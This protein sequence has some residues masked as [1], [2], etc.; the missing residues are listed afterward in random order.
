MG[1]FF[2]D[3]RFRSFV[4]YTENVSISSINNCID[5][6]VGPTFLLKFNYNCRIVHNER[7]HLKY[8]NLSS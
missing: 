6:Q 7:D 3:W 8:T 1:F 2:I 4:I 5:W